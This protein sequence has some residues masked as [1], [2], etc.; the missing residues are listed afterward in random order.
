[1]STL[2]YLERLP[3]LAL[4][5]ADEANRSAH[6]DRGVVGAQ[7]VPHLTAGAELDV[8]DC[9]VITEAAT[10][11]AL[12]PAGVDRLLRSLERHGAAGLALALRGD[13]AGDVPPVVRQT[14][15]RLSIP[16]MTTR[17]RAEVWTCVDRGL[18]RTWQ[19]Q[20]TQHM[21]RIAQYVGHLPDGFHRPD[22]PEH[23]V[24]GLSKSLAAYVLFVDST[25]GE[26]RAEYP[27]DAPD[28]HRYTAHDI[29]LSKETSRSPQFRNALHVVKLTVGRS[30][31]ALFL[32][33]VSAT[34]F[35]GETLALA[36]HTAK[37]LVLAQ[38][39][40]Q[41]RRLT[42]SA[43]GVRLGVFQMLIGGQI[44]LA[45]R[46]MEGLS[47]GLLQVEHVRVYVI[48]TPSRS[49]DELV[50]ALEPVTDG[51]AL[52][53]RCPARNDHIIAVEPLRRTG[54]AA[55]GTPRAGR[56]HALVDVLTDAIA[57]RPGC[58][59]GGSRPYG[60]ADVADAYSEAANA[61]VSAHHN[62][63]RV[64]MF[65]GSSQLAPLLGEAAHS[66]A[67]HVLAPVLGLPYVV[68]DELIGTMRIALDFPY[69]ETARI[70]G[71]HRNTVAARAARVAEVLGG[72]GRPLDLK[73]VRVR[74]VLH[75]AL[76]LFRTW[77]PRGG[78]VPDEPSL[79]SILRSAPARTWAEDLLHPLRGAAP[80]LAP[81]V[82]TW[83][84][85][86]L[87]IDDTAEAVGVGAATVR[88]RLRQAEAL[89]QR[90]LSTG[91]A[92]AHALTLA[93]ATTTGDPS[94]PTLGQDRLC[95]RDPAGPQDCA[96][97]PYAGDGDPA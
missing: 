38:D 5:F 85:C 14:A 71:A 53:V 66:W 16:L 21:E 32:V 70:L 57:G 82:R 25:V 61:L 9:L 91:L 83:V 60:L 37:L 15:L 89:L 20:A 74:T 62:A 93:L 40:A 12:A 39:V 1:M 31:D 77:N 96:P 36:E 92:G 8:A 26:V 42:D 29:V 78:G 48:A 49:R 47:P 10:L 4:A 58:A 55:G 41:V 94:L 84:R 22:A 7:F 23:L 59:I 65:D 97:V 19:R 24:T 34:P 75:L 54:H 69:T 90:D 44:V 67:E 56:P 51:R 33:M 64:G 81:T 18:S 13:P 45:Q 46:A 72:E 80:S 3:E 73:D 30:A 43:R 28:V 17:A 2:G 68:R 76:S 63:E 86:N 27:L 6:H 88:K 52:L 50:G 11:T 87:H 79:P 35:E 95:T